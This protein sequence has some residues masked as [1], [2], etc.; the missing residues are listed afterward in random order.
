M[1]T[2]GITFRDKFGYALGDV[3]SCLFLGMIGPFLQMF[4]TDV[5][6]LS[7]GSITVLLLV[8]RIWD[9]INDPLLGAFID[10]RPAGKHGKFRPYLRIFAVPLSISAVLLFTRIPGLSQGQ[11]LIY[12]YITHILYE[13]CFTGVNIP[14]GSMTSVITDDGAER[15]QLSVYR[16]IGSGL[17]G[18]PASLILPMFV[19]STAESGKEYL[20]DRKLFIAMLILGVIGI[21]I[22]MLCFKMTKERVPPPPIEK[23]HHAMKTIG[24]LLRNRPYLVVCFASMLLVG[25]AFYSQAFNNFLFKDYF[26]QPKLY[27][28]VTVATYLPTVAILPFL[29]KLVARFGKKRLCAYGILLASLANFAALIV[30]TENPYVFLLFCLL[31]GVGNIFLTLQIWAMAADVIDYQELLSHERSEGT[32]YAFFSFTRKIG[33]T[34]AGSG[35]SYLLDQIGYDVKKAE[36]KIPQTR[37]VAKRMYTS[38]TLVPAIAFFLIFIA[39]AF[40]YSLGKKEEEAMREELRAR[41]EAEQ[42]AIPEEGD[43]QTL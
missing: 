43:V 16:S 26:E 37:A 41:R 21:T 35:S 27:M 40:F 29:G 32:S 34:L 15:S 9:G 17:G 28:F 1:Q 10:R 42:T 25:L 7:L 18:L 11:Y 8:L 20:D 22:F 5:L 13:M 36:M 6:H 19:Y 31:T 38:A 3:A 12:A 24:S 33:Q 39:L 2:S 14:Y 23:D 30:R 4:Y